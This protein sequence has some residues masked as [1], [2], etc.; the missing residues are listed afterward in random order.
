MGPKGHLHLPP[1]LRGHSV[2]FTDPR[3]Q[4]TF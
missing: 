3:A 4:A 2:I 1:Q